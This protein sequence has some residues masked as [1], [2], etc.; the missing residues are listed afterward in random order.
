MD[1]MG[2]GVDTANRDEAPWGIGH[3]VNVHMG[4]HMG[5]TSLILHGSEPNFY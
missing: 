5:I 2:K 3:M 1:H 4:K